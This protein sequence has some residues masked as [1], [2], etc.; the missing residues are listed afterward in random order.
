MIP[1]ANLLVVAAIYV[2]V[3]QRIDG[4]E[5]HLAVAASIFEECG[6]LR[7]DL[8]ESF[9]IPFDSVHLS[10]HAANPM[11]SE[12]VSKQRMLSGLPFFL[13]T[14]FILTQ[15][16]RDHQHSQIGL[17]GSNNHVWNVILSPRSVE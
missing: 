1:A 13:E 4:D 6:H 2:D 3:R 17:T 16:G 12:G 15:L 11:Y 7:L 10:Y 5:C 14:T 8:M 9:G